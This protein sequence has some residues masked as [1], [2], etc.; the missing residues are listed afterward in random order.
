MRLRVIP[1]SY[2]TLK[3]QKDSIQ[4][5]ELRRQAGGLAVRTIVNNSHLYIADPAKKNEIEEAF[6]KRVLDHQ[7]GR[8]VQAK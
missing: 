1:H 5:S 8:V 6:A 7:V 3:K 2:Q 4:A